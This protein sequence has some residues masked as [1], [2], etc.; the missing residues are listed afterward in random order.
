MQCTAK[1]NI[2]IGKDQLQR[3]VVGYQSTQRYVRSYA[4]D[5]G[6][7]SRMVDG[8]ARDLAGWAY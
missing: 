8:I 7:G 1:D 2:P 6:S 5:I 4:R 3:L